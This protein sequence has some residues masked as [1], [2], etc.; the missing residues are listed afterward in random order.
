MTFVGASEHVQLLRRVD[1]FSFNDV[2]AALSDV[3]L[4]NVQARHVH[5]KTD[6]AVTTETT[7]QGFNVI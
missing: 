3:T 6:K 4:V 1:V 2:R 5:I 7:E